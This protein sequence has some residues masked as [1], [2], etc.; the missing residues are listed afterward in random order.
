MVSADVKIDDLFQRG[1]LSNLEK[2]HARVLIGDL[3]IQKV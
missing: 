2:H 1:E 3:D